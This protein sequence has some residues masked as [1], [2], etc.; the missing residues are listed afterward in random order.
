MALGNIHRR[1]AWQA[2]HLWGWAGSGDALG[3]GGTPRGAVA[4]A[5]LADIRRRFAWQ[6]WHLA[7]STVVLRGRRGPYGTGLALVTRLVRAGRRGAPR[8]AAP[9]CVAGAALGD[10][11]RRFAWQAWHLATS[12]VVLR[13]RRGTYGTV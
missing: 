1:F 6:A 4:G 13:G 5:A 10:I 3:P 7:T 8:D 12:T 9:F 11:R 2:W